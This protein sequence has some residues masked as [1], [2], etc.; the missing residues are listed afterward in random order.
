MQVGKTQKPSQSSSTPIAIALS[1]AQWI[2]LALAALSPG[3]AMADDPCETTDIHATK[4]ADTLQRASAR[5]PGKGVFHVEQV[6]E[7]GEGPTGLPSFIVTYRTADDVILRQEVPHPSADLSDAFTLLPLPVDGGASLGVKY[8]SG[9]G[10]AIVC[11]YVLKANDGRFAA[12]RGPWPLSPRDRLISDLV[13]AAER[14]NLKG[15][16]AA[17][18]AGADVNGIHPEAGVGAL[19]FAAQNGHLPVV[20]ALLDSGA[21]VDGSGGDHFTPLMAAV[22]SEHEQ[23]VKELIQRGANPHIQISGGTTAISMAE[24]GGQADILKLLQEQRGA[25]SAAPAANLPPLPFLDFS[26]QVDLVAGKWTLRKAH[27]LLKRVSL[28]PTV[29]AMVPEG[30]TVEATKVGI[31]TRSYTVY[32]AKKALDYE[33]W[34]WNDKASKYDERRVSLKQGELVAVLSYFGEG[35]CRVWVRGA[36]HIG[37][38][39]DGGGDD[40]VFSKDP[41]YPELS[42]EIWAAVVTNDGRGGY[43]RNP[44]AEGM[45]KHD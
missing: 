17:I 27:E 6:G 24:S 26:Y 37:F 30:S 7:Y 2:A 3:H 29:I 15:V 31:L 41:A 42:T 34:N 35:E 36:A 13:M 44:D 33:I 28:Q 14:G 18:R 10:G 16:T 12:R 38:C 43:L 25:V 4:L 20:K 1:T 45:S 21:H 23:I 5:K 22:N 11:T 8:A 9:A 40:G 39:P 32:K 19:F